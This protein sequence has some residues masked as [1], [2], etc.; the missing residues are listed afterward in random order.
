MH[1][2]IAMAGGPGEREEGRALRMRSWPA[3]GSMSIFAQGPVLKARVG[4][5]GS[6]KKSMLQPGIFFMTT[7]PRG[8]CLLTY[9]V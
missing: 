6:H 2:T 9:R 1:E 8:H 7:R 5:H 3:L 4:H